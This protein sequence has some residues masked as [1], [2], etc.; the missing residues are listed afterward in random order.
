MATVAYVKEHLPKVKVKIGKKVYSGTVRG[1]KNA[2]ASVCVGGECHEVS[3][4]T[5]ARCYTAKTA[6]RF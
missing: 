5:V 4:E 6:I 2:F 1:R 3:W